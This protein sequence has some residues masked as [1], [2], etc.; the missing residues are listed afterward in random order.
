MP[1]PVV[2]LPHLVMMRT[3]SARLRVLG[4]FLTGGSL[5]GRRGT[6]SRGAPRFPGRGVVPG[7]GGVSSRYARV[8]LGSE[9]GDTL[10]EVVISALVVGLIVV[11]TLTGFSDVDRATAQQRAHNEA[12]VLADQSQ[13]QLRSDPASVLETIAPPS[14]GH[15]YEQTVSG[16]IYTITQKAELQPQTGS[17]ASCSV[18]ETKRQS[19]NAFSITSTV[20]WLTQKAT[21]RSAVTA[22]SIVTPPTGSALEVDA[23]N[24]PVATSGVTGVTAHVTYTPAESSSTTSV[25][26]TTGPEGCLVFGGI[27]ATS[28]LVE[29][30]ETAGYVTISGSS[31]YPTKEVTIAPNYTSHYAVVY[32][33]GGAIKAEF[34]YEK[35][36]KYKHANN[37]GVANAVEEEVKGDTFVA[38]N[39]KMKLAPEFEV[40]STRYGTG[41]GELY[42]PLPGVTSPTPTY[43][44]TAES[45]FNLFPF[46]ESENGYWGVYA[47]DCTENNPETI[48]SGA[49][50]LPEKIIV[51]PGVATPAQV[52]M[53]Y[54]KLNLYAGTEAQAK[55]KPHLYEALETGASYPVTITNTKCAGKTP[56]NETAVKDEHTQATTIN[57]TSP[58]NGGHLTDP[59]QP[60]GKEFELC[61][62]AKGE[63]FTTTK[64]ENKEAKGAELSIYLGQLLST[65]A[66]KKREEAEASYKAKKAEYEAK[67]A[68]YKAKEAYKTKKAESEAKKAASKTEE[69]KYTN[70]LAK[71]NTEKTKYTNELAKY[72]T[73][74]TKYNTEKTN[75]EK[76]KTEY[77][78]AKEKNEV[79]KE[80]EDKT[81]YEAA[82][83][84]YEAAKTAYEAAKTAYL[85]AETAYKTAEAAYKAAETAYKTDETE[86]K[87]DAQEAAEYET[88]KAEAEADYKESEKDKET[89][90]TAKVAE[91]EASKTKVTVGTGSCP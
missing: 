48:S 63:T 39:T 3:I 70:E 28:A 87:T 4:R 32:N 8:L 31:K 35:Q 57:S 37:E 59:F 60:F 33:R 2:A 77:T 40:G 24:A 89:Y 64:Y 51:A 43:E 50:K 45:K 82:K 44:H 25:E 18:T 56:D 36:P 16:T 29:I 11:G 47:G 15:S 71:Y 55:A 6:L 83:T 30:K 26:Q 76:Y 66:V 12:A 1:K 22:S 75:Y 54:V 91:E 5:A 62:T 58:G 74:N 67:E 80:A 61:V 65:E 27:P 72:N 20:T 68:A 78:K 88:P 79:A 46:T 34:I 84:A 23:D 14:A 90:E 41:S 49:V 81:K 73:E 69:T 53:S 42:E 10:I 52:P 38:L 7:R 19:G 21:K 86:Y 85:A 9:R 13:E 17:G